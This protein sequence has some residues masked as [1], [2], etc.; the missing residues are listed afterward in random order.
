MYFIEV[1]VELKY[2]K[3][4]GGGQENETLRYSLFNL[5]V[6]L[7]LRMFTSPL[8]SLKSIGLQ[9]N[10]V[11]DRNITA[12]YAIISLP[13]SNKLGKALPPTE[14]QF[15]P[16]CALPNIF[17]KATPLPHLCPNSMF[18]STIHRFYCTLLN[19]KDSSEQ[20]V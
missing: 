3:K 15:A 14:M 5:Y 9:G 16:F 11:E 2:N 20:H 18:F 19:D 17:S 12:E 1:I 8:M 6:I 7:A 10:C 13:E 4:L